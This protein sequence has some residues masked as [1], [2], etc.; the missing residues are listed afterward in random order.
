M[1][2]QIIKHGSEN[3][4]KM[5]VLRTEILR[6]PLGLA[7]T[8]AQ[9]SAEQSDILIGAFENEAIKGCCILSPAKNTEMQLRQMAVATSQQGQG[10]GS[11]IIQFAEQYAIENGYTSMMLHA[12][13]TALEFYQKLGYQ[14][15]GDEYFE[16]GLAHFSMRK[17]L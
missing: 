13:K 16:V 14:A 15:F 6:K 2:I 1:N 8:E 7:Y 9:L 4:Q 12:R 11:A 3:Y 10:V 5:V 17:L